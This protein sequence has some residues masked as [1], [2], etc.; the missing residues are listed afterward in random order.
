M[1]RQIGEVPTRTF[2]PGAVIFREGDDA[3]GEAFMV[4]QGRVEIRKQIGGEDRLLR[5]L[6]KGELL[7]HIALFRNAPRSASAIAADAVTLM[8]I[9]ANRLDHLVRANPALALALIRD[10][11]TMMLAAE[12]R[13]REVEDRLGRK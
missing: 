1:S 6:T 4:H 12:D 9:S 11:S 13:L 10:L 7:G 2:E 8:V 5:A 3:K